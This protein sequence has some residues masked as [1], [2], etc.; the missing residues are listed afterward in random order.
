M[1]FSVK[2]VWNPVLP[3][4]PLGLYTA[5]LMNMPQLPY[6]RTTS[7][8]L[9]NCMQSIPTTS[10][11]L[12]YQ[13]TVLRINRVGR[14]MHKRGRDN[15]LPLWGAVCVKTTTVYSCTLL[16]KYRWCLLYIVDVYLISPMFIAGGHLVASDF[17]SIY[18]YGSPPINVVDV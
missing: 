12:Y 11:L 2:N 13:I 17:T 3:L 15:T 7:K 18:T 5:F 9:K 14:R 1:S 8:R 16:L 10:C 4:F 6:C